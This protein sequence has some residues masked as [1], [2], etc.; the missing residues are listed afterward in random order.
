MSRYLITDTTSLFMS[1]NIFTVNGVSSTVAA[2]NSLRSP[3]TSSTAM[4]EYE[5]SMFFDIITS[6]ENTAVLLVNTNTLSNNRI[7]S[8]TILPATTPNQI[9]S[10]TV[11]PTITNFPSTNGERSNTIV[12]TPTSYSIPSEKSSS[13]SSSAGIIV[14]VTVAGIIIL[15]ATMT[16]I[17]V[18]IVV[19]KKRVERK[20]RINQMQPAGNYQFSLAATIKFSEK[21]SS[22]D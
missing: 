6:I 13:S 1:T 5:T 3:D 4:F 16:C 18:F 11:L 8:T 22:L 17:V 20:Y 10:V 19:R 12:D 15:I 14:G 9:D 7:G 2:A 21:Y